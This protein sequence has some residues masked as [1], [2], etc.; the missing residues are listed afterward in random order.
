MQPLSSTP[1]NDTDPTVPKDER[2]REEE[3]KPPEPRPA[4]NPA[5][6]K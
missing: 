2:A 6:K 1:S 5:P 4:P 3:V